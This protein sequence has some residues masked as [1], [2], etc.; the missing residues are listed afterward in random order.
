MFYGIMWF[1]ARGIRPVPP[2]AGEGRGRGW[3]GPRGGRGAHLGAG[4]AGCVGGGAGRGE[5]ERVWAVWGPGARRPGRRRRSARPVLRRRA[6]PDKGGAFLKRRRPLQAATGMAARAVAGWGRWPEGVGPRAWRPGLAGAWES[7]VSPATGKDFIGRPGRGDASAWSARFLASLNPGAPTAEQP[8]AGIGLL[9]FSVRKLRL[10]A[11]Q[12]SEAPN[13][14][15]WPSLHQPR[16]GTQSQF[17]PNPQLH[18]TCSLL[19]NGEAQE[20]PFPPTCSA[21]A[22]STSQPT[23]K[24]GRNH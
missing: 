24:G 23:L 7:P 2:P 11:Q 8:F 18:P 21:P 22:P 14:S 9:H 1:D 17:C 16:E 4:W 20:I 12:T 6:A 3:A 15:L 5:E 13:P 19:W 10:K